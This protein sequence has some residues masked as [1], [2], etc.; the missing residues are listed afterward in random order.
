MFVAAPNAAPSWLEERGGVL[1]GDRGATV[2]GL[3]QRVD[4]AVDAQRLGA[5]DRRIAALLDRIQ[6]IRQQ[7]PTPVMRPRHRMGAR[8][9]AAAVAAELEAAAVMIAHSERGAGERRGRARPDELDALRKAWE[10]R[11]GGI[12]RAEGA[13][14]EASCRTDQ[15]LGLH[16]MDARR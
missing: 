5:A 11:R 9:G 2:R 1:Y 4:Q 13:V 12:D 3:Q 10:R 16:S 7:G 14:G 15:I 8:T 6:Q